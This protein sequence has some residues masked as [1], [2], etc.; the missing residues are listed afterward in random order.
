MLLS[1]SLTYFTIEVSVSIINKSF[2]VVSKCDILFV[3][4]FFC[5]SVVTCCYVCTARMPFC[6]NISLWLSTRVIICLRLYLAPRWV[7]VCSLPPSKGPCR[8]TIK[9]WY[10]DPLQNACVDFIYGGCNGN[11]NN[12]AAKSKCE[13]VCRF[14]GQGDD[15]IDYHG[16]FVATGAS[17]LLLYI[18]Q[19]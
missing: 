3:L 17:L 1:L 11:E 16:C 9:R 8:A 19:Y 12:F 13:E 2:L 7:E 18:S 6:C 10:Y 15:D 14:N 5:P 4:F